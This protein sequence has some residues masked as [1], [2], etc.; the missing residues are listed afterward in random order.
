MVSEVEEIQNHI[1][2]YPHAY[3]LTYVSNT[4][5]LDSLL[6]WKLILKKSIFEMYATKFI[7][8]GIYFI[9]P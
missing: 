9:H 2:L 3:L 8:K 7:K 1:V 5:A 4:K 6:D